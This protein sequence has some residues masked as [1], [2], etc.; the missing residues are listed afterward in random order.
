MQMRGNLTA[1]TKDWPVK[2]LK[3]GNREVS[4]KKLI[5][6]AGDREIAKKTPQG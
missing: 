4:E 3:Y 5:T 2:G 1:L 6:L